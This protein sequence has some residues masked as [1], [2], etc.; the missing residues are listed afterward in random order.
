[1]SS[2]KRKKIEGGEIGIKDLIKK[3]KSDAARKPNDWAEVGKF[4]VLTFKS[5]GDDFLHQE[6]VRIL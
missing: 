5:D 6:C 4:R 2:K 3:V 1:M